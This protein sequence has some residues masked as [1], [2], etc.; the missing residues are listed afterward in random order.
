[1][2]K[3]F[4]SFV[5]IFVCCV[6]TFAQTGNFKPFVPSVNYQKALIRAEAILQKM[7]V[8]EKIEM[9]RG[10]GF[11]IA[12]FKKYDIPAVN[13]TDASQ[14]IRLN[15]PSDTATVNLTKKSVAFPAPVA[16]AATWNTRLAYQYAQAIG[17]EAR[18][19]AINV[20]LGPGLNIY[21]IS[22]NGRNFEYLG[23]DPY[24]VSRMVENY[25]AGMQNT[26]TMAVIKHFVANN[27]DLDRRK[28]NSVI[29][30]RALH[31]IYM[32]AFKAGIDA[33][34]MG[35]MTSYNL[36]NGEWAGQSEYV[37]KQLL[38]KEL[39][40]KG[41]V[42]T[43][44]TSVWDGEKVIKSGQNL[45]MPNGDALKT[46]RQL[47]DAGKVNIADIDDMVK[48]IMTACI[49]MGFYDNKP[50]IKEEEGKPYPEHEEVALQTAREGIVL[51]KN[52]NGILPLNTGAPVLVMGKYVNKNALGGGSARVLGY[53][54][55]NL[56]AALSATFNT[57]RFTEQLTDAEIKAAPYIILSTGTNDAEAIDRPFNL[58]KAEND[59]ILRICNLNSRTIVVVSS[60]S[61]INMNAWKDKAAAILY[62]WY[63]GQAGQVALAEI[64]SGKINPSGKLPFTIE[65]DFH[66]S[67]GF[68]YEP[69]DR[70][71]N[72]N[73]PKDGDRSKIYNVNYREG[74]FVGYRW[75][76]HQNITPLFPFGYGL[77]YTNFSYANLKTDIKSFKSNGTIKVSFDI[78]N[79]G[80]LD[81]AEVAQLYIADKHSTVERPVKELKGF[82]KILIKKGE[83]T[84]VTLLL[85]KH[86]F[87]YWHPKTK[88]WT[89]EP[90]KFNLLV[91]SS[92][93]LIKLNTTV[94]L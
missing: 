13:F 41:L 28:S 8:D 93:A 91:G 4:V 35:V 19:K 74:I 3:A 55:V 15:A 71:M 66:D 26:G 36:V 39:G 31:E 77:S 32:P 67:P 37:I 76:E 51:L 94:I 83:L 90:G 63:P 25:V 60:G 27:T 7:T 47:L 65:K 78:K 87:E 45:E 81:G 46:T 2:K 54:N 72:K 68:G 40:F 11:H 57:I 34:A 17:E 42:M 23:E 29:D 44:W 69:G 85:T 56:K 12:E 24:L 92:S 61:G 84:T 20:L 70:P 86:D 62:A 82:K 1:M 88:S 21:R 16:L 73:A 89:F 18:S 75:Y 80:T 50:L 38:R 79:M 30:E 48:H 5:I 14:G 53:N 58:S 6:C 59:K 9:I 43:D 10:K 22:Q 49:M 52:E 33:G 64:L